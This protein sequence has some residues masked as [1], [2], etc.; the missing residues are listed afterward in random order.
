V[1]VISMAIE[2]LFSRTV[3]SCRLPQRKKA[4]LDATDVKFA[5]VRGDKSD[6]RLEEM[7]KQIIERV[8]DLQEMHSTVQLGREKPKEEEALFDERGFMERVKFL[9]QRSED[10][11]RRRGTNSD[12][13]P[14]SLTLGLG[15]G[16]STLKGRPTDPNLSGGHSGSNKS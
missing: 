3:N 13:N 10:D 5:P 16:S 1:G 9:Y 6:V 7:F 8:E 4:M 12:E 14:E 15:A 2:Q 11:V